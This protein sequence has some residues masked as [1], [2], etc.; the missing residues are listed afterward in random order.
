MRMPP[1]YVFRD[2]T[3]PWLLRIDIDDR[4]LKAGETTTVTVTFSEAVSGLTKEHLSVPNGTLSD[5]RS[6]DGGQTWT[7]TL[8]PASNTTAHYNVI[9]VNNLSGVTDADGNTA[10]GRYFTSMPYTVDTQ[11]PTLTRITVSDN[12]LTAGET[13]TVTATFDEQVTGFNKNHL[14][15]PNGTLGNLYSIDGGRTW[16]GTLTPTA[17]VTDASNAISVNNLSGVK[18]WAGNAATG[19]PTSNNYEVNATDTEAPVL[20]GATVNGKRL[21]LSY[22][23]ATTLDA[24]HT[25]DK[26][27]F[28]VLVDGTA[29]AVTAVTV[30][31]TAKTVTLT[32]TT[33]VTSGQRVTVSY[34]D[35][36]TGNDVNATQDAAGNDA[37]SFAARSVT[38]Y[39]PSTN[40]PGNPYDRTAPWLTR[41]DIDDRALKVGETATV[42][43]TFSKAVSGLT[44]E[45]LSVPNGTLSELSSADGGRTWTGT[46][47]PASDTTAR[48][49]VIS[50]NN[51]SGVTDADGNTATGHYSTSWPYAVDTKA[52]ALT[53]ITVNDSQLTAGK[54]TTVTFTFDE[55]VTGFTKN[56][57]SVPNGTLSELR[58]IDGGQTWTGTL[59]PTANATD[60]S[61]TIGVSNLS[62]V[63]DWSGNA[64]TGSPTSNNYEVNSTDTESPV[65]RGATVNGNR[66]VLSYT[67]ATTLDATH[68]ADKG[69]FT[70]LVDGTA[71]AVTATAVDATAKT[72]T[73]T[74]TTAVT[75]SQ[76]VTVSY[77]DPTTGNDANAT[78]DAAGNDAASFAARSVSNNTAQDTDNDG[79]SNAVED[80]V[81][82][83]ARFH[84][85]ATVAGDGNGDG[86]KDSGQSAVCSNASV[87]LVAGSQ[88]GKL[89]ADNGT[90]ITSLEQK[91]APANYSGA[92]EM[93]I[94][95][96]E[97][98]AELGAGTRTEKF[99]LYVDPAQ[100]VNGYWVQNQSGTW[101]N[102]ASSPYGG[103]MVL[104]GDRLRLDFQITDG[105][106]YDAD[107][108]A[109]GVITASGAAA[110]R[111]PLHIVG[112]ASDVGLFGWFWF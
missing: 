73:L 58:S 45:H 3:A 106:E 1:T 111:M 76:N 68:K 23:E 96:T 78:Q 91:D 15:V 75:V 59:T 99:S 46:L 11:A 62:G 95:L 36:T 97:F 31:A 9:S 25:A 112:H 64:A 47:T 24:T 52:P 20:R 19:S 18:D 39:T 65:L 102:L 29:N 4:T 105:G 41:I 72:V 93:P 55:Q 33:A 42:T 84:G 80:Q 35:P 12:N 40:Y 2:R 86:I 98:R 6:T 69:A 82:G 83:L 8:T 51:L 81:R 87:T 26:G 90:R 27:A 50:V 44:K 32:L 21:V 94:G 108:Q 14:S 57:L 79:V 56:H 38:N 89:K 53:R 17:N 28:A 13:T 63:K 77:T 103:K 60:A 10:T 71:N 74:L 7:G 22:T 30:D 107:G 16:T 66:L 110:A 34:T 104:E 48:Y 101:V 5:L 85:A 100:G 37:A 88:N 49:N 54:T 92:L 70:V 109:D 43:I 67:E 61:N